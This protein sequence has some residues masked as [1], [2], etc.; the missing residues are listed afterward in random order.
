M[1]I[2]GAGYHSPAKTGAYR[3]LCEDICGETMNLLNNGMEACK[4]VAHAVSLLEVIPVK[5]IIDVT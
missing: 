2:K 3:I 5:I 4:A 1:C